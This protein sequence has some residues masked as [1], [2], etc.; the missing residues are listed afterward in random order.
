MP[1]KKY[2]PAREIITYCTREQ[3]RKAEEG[4]PRFAG[5]LVGRSLWFPPRSSQPP[6]HPSASSPP[7]LSAGAQGDKTYNAWVSSNNPKRHGRW[8]RLSISQNFVAIKMNLYTTC[9]L[10]LC[11][12]V[13][14]RYST[15]F[16][17]KQPIFVSLVCKKY[18]WKKKNKTC[19]VGAD[20]LL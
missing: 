6:T 18:F 20:L 12:Q 2:T 17:N 11:C 3:L 1:E 8:K 4:P 16:F 19:K 5:S 13:F 14:G 9:P 7:A 15:A 10:S